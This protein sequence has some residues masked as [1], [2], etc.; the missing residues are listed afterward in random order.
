MKPINAC[1]VGFIL[2]FWLMGAGMG[3]ASDQH[4]FGTSLIADIAEKVSPAV[5][6]IESVQFVRTR[7]S[8]SFGDPFFDRFFNHMLDED[9]SGYNNVIPRRGT[10]S[11][12]IISEDGHLLTNQHVI[13]EA[14]EI[15]V[16]LV[17]GRKIKASIIGQ[18]PQS[19]LAVLQLQEK[20][21]YPFVA[22]G[23]SDALRVG[24]WVV[25][26]GNPFSLGIT[27]TAGVVSALGR[28]LSVDRQRNF[29]NLIQTDASI[30]PGNSGGP[31]LNTK[32]EVIGINTAIVPYGQGI[33]F[34]I[35]VSSARRIIGDLMSYGK[36]REVFLGIAGQDINRSLAE[37]FEIPEKG[38]LVT[39]VASGSPAA[40][41]GIQPGD[42]VQAVNRKPI[43]NLREFHE[44]ISRHRIGE[45]V[46]ITMFRKG[47]TGEAELELAELPD[48]TK[49]KRVPNRLGVTVV[50][51]SEATRNTFGIKVKNGVVVARVD[52]ES[53][54]AA[55]GLEPGDVIRAL[56][57][58]PVEKPA[59]LYRQ[60][61]QLPPSSRTLLE[62]VRG[63]LAT[64]VYLLLP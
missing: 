24:D 45:R 27:V 47:R 54:G 44:A 3:T 22:L 26:I 37:Y 6:T 64:L 33:G 18:D 53:P 35:P 7:R 39:E 31:L 4:P 25:A 15:Q 48:V 59:D 51:N 28:D 1:R 36:V 43:A 61:K 21:I 32:G 49:V 20:G 38:F 23:D 9:F 29:R 58:R 40:K 50:E 55:L 13:A 30:N 10:G 17:G 16:A 60:L 62:V 2:F 14:D 34:A 11:G 42:V 5:V 12:V 41:A 8:F 56:N 46:G 63:S 57:R 19:D 52:P